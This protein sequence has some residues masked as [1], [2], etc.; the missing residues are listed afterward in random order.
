[1]FQML[2]F[3]PNILLLLL[4]NKKKFLILY[5]ISLT[6]IHNTRSQDMV[7]IYNDTLT[8]KVIH[9]LLPIRFDYLLGIFLLKTENY[10]NHISNIRNTIEVVSIN[11]Q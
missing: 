8:C 1:M 2:V 7:D 3:K 6:D 10:S 5:L 9:P 4:L 11:I